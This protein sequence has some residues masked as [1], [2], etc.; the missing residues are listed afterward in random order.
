MLNSWFESIVDRIGPAVQVYV[1]LS[2]Q[3]SVYYE[4]TSIEEYIITISPYEK[5]FNYITGWP[6][7]FL[8]MFF[9]YKSCTT[10]PGKLRNNWD[11]PIKDDKPGIQTCFKCNHSKPLRTS[12]CRRCKTCVVRRDH[13]C[14]FTNNCVGFNNHK[15]FSWF[16]LFGFMGCMHFI[17][18]G[19]QW[20]IEWY[21]GD[22]LLHYSTGYAF[23][24][25]VHVYNMTGFAGLLAS[26][27][28]KNFKNIFNNLT[29][30]DSWITQKWCGQSDMNLY[31]LGI[32]YNW[33]SV[34]GI[35]PLLWITPSPP[36]RH[37]VIHGP[38]FPV[39]P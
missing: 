37:S 21:Y 17:L 33:V 8:T 9:Y 5:P 2:I 29:I 39:N 22:K 3:L 38:D 28:F 25:A 32:V 31:D 18:R 15:S 11:A 6:L 34:F 30:M 16:L 1:V 20:E 36:S 26:I 35:N 24:L 4:I 27:M 13:H 10:H 23:L 14:L 7:Y 19:I 12:H